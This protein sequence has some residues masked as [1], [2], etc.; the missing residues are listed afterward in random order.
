MSLGMS[1]AV[2]LLLLGI[3]GTMVSGGV[4]GASAGRG[5]VK[6]PT[7]ANL[8]GPQV[9][10]ADGFVSLRGLIGIRGSSGHLTSGYVAIQ[11]RP[12]ATASWR[13]L[14]RVAL[15]SAGTFVF[16]TPVGATGAQGGSN[17]FF[18]VV[19]AGDATHGPSSQQSTTEVVTPSSQLPPQSPPTPVPTV[20]VPPTVPV[21]IQIKPDAFTEVQV[22]SWT[23]S[24][25]T[26]DL[27]RYVRPLSGLT[28]A[29]LC[30][31]Q[32]ESYEEDF[33]LTNQQGTGTLTIKALETVTP[34]GSV[35][36]NQGG[37]FVQTGVWVITSPTGDYNGVTGSGTTLWLGGTLTLALTGVMTKVS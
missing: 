19:F 17:V 3:A 35:P 36:V 22:G 30:T 10:Q 6:Q 1:R 11:S 31:L 2:L 18:R 24:G 25:A 33:V 34:T 5:A 15:K 37:S 27:G 21:S 16:K 26:N 23:A 28:P 12:A 32:P 8:V 29:C 13:T 7:Y 20:P 9:V 4:A 14:T